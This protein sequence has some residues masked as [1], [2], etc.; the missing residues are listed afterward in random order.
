MQPRFEIDGVVWHQRHP[1]L[2]FIVTSSVVC[3]Q[4]RCERRHLCN[5]YQYRLVASEFAGQYKMACDMY[6]HRHYEVGK[7]GGKV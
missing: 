5:G 2:V 1:E 3:D 7:H 4:I 6:M